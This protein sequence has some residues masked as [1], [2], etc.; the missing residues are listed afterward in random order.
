LTCALEFYDRRR[1]RRTVRVGAQARHQGDRIDWTAEV[2]LGRLLRPL[3]FVDRV[4][5]VRMRLTAGDEV[6]KTRLSTYDDAHGGLAVPVRPRLSRLAADHL[7]TYI[8]DHAELAFQLTERQR[9]ALAMGALVQRIIGTKIGRSVWSGVALS[10][11]FVRK[12]LGHPRT[13]VFVYRTLLTRLPIRKRTIVFESDRGRQYAGNPKY[14]HAELRRAKTAHQAV[15]SYS[16]HS[17]GFPKG[18]KL[19]KRG[20]WA[21]HRA[22][23]RAEFWVDDQGGFPAELPKRARTTYVQTGNGSAFKHVGMDRPDVKAA[24][25]DR[26]ERLLA[27][28]CRFDHYLVRSEHDAAAFS[29]AFG[30]RAEP[31]RCGYP[32]NDALVTGGDREELA[33]LRRELKLGDGRQVVLYAPTYRDDANGKP[34]A[35]FEMPFD[36]ERF[37]RELGDTHL[38]LLRPHPRTTIVLPPELRHA[39]RNVA[40]TYDITSLMLLSDA[41]VTDYSSVMFDFALLGRPIVCYAPELDNY[42]EKGRGSYLNL[43]EQVPGPVVQEEDALFG[44][45]RDLDELGERYGQQVSDFA[46]RFGEYDDGAAA[47]A[48]VERL[49]TSGRTQ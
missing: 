18:T 19:V 37:A 41:L 11:R 32:R 12:G 24:T 6:I 39:V 8:T 17:R 49:F 3:G 1:P 45:L 27:E 21:Y 29:R 26:Q 35:R 36:L 10:E 13:K 38:L 28:A 15:W 25:R 9:P 2:E 48:V 43:A 22:V 33:K 30:L 47:Q 44:A 20:S 42:V 46:K 16:G 23:A 4:W 7:E 34:V 5:D 31:L 40:G 14:I